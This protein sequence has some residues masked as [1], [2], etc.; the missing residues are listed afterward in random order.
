MSGMIQFKQDEGAVYHSRKL[1][2]TKLLS[3]T[4]TQGQLDESSGDLTT[5]F[6]TRSPQVFQLIWDCDEWTLNVSSIASAYYFQQTHSS[7]RNDSGK[8]L[9][10]PERNF[11]IIFQNFPILLVPHDFL[12]F[13]P[14]NDNILFFFTLCFVLHHMAQQSLCES[15]LLNFAMI[16]EKMCCAKLA[17]CNTMSFF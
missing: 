5:P 2:S 15:Q 12:K 8:G 13:W 16:S 14:L 1:V 9:H 4:L 6:S 11:I 7:R 3:R 10:D 17:R